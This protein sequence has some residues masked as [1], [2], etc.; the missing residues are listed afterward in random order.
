VR[1]NAIAATCVAIAV[2]FPAVALAQPADPNVARAEALFNS[3]KQLRDAGLYVDACPQ[4]AQSSRLAPG[5][6]AS[7][8]LADCYE[9]IGRTTSAWSEF[10]NAEKLARDRS[11]PRADMAHARAQALEPK[12]SGL[13]ISV[14]PAVAHQSPEVLL[15]GAKIPPEEWNAGI[16]ADPGDHV[17][18]V[19]IPGQASRTLTAHVDAGTRSAT[20][21]IDEAGA[22]PATSTPAAETVAPEPPTPVAPGD[23]GATRRWVGIGLL[24]AGVVGVGIGTALVVNKTESP[25]GASCTP[26]PQDNSSTVASAIAFAAGGAAILTGVIL[27]LSAPGGKTVGVVAAPLFLAGGGGAVVR[28]NF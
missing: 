10:R 4:F 1:R 5:V 2:L 6:G 28:A 15:D 23:P 17:V 26:Q 11:D 27:T 24:G 3:A 22:A 8:Y 14:P 21:R 9:H 12:L 16:A 13:T 20:V 19:I 7:L 18:T 25:S